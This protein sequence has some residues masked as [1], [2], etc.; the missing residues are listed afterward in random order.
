MLLDSWLA[1]NFQSINQF[2][3][4]GDKRPTHFQNYSKNLFHI[5][6][7]WLRSASFMSKLVSRSKFAELIL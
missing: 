6:S 1:A 7:E 3:H 4:E 2:E 5:V